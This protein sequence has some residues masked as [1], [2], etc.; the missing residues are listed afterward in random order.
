MQG[1]FLIAVLHH[2]IR[3]TAANAGGFAATVA[4]GKHQQQYQAS[5]FADHCFIIPRLMSADSVASP[6]RDNSP[7]VSVIIPARNEEACLAKCLASL[8]GQQG[9]SCEI[10]LVNDHSTDRTREIAA[11]FAAVR[12]IDA[13]PLPAGWSG[14][15]NAC[16][17]GAQAARGQWLL[18]TDADTVHNSGS[19]ARSVAEAEEHGAALLSYSPRQ[20]VHGFWQRAL[21]PV[22]FAELR[23]VYP[24][25]DVSGPASPI[26]A[27]NGQYLLI[28][29]DVYF[30]VGGHAAIAQ[31]LLEDVALARAVKQL[32]HLI[33]FR[34]GG[35]AVST[36]MYRSFAEMWSGWTKNLAVLFPSAR[37]LAFRRLAEFATAAA[38]VALLAAGLLLS[39]YR[40]AVVGGAVAVPT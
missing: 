15:S 28:R 32:G 17:T 1:N 12:V 26:A 2:K 36:R 37:M 11:S 6:S 3:S 34:Y 40:L 39:D 7:R 29:R 25:K 31:T 8:V 19:L 30:Q 14:K 35:D 24:P 21:M 10:L 9:I 16:W 4:A 5:N 33:R 20:E 13:P 38:G 18:F 22:V 27:A 23:R